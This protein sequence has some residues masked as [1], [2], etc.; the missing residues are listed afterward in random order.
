MA[1]TDK[2]TL[3]IRSL[4]RGPAPRYITDADGAIF[5]VEPGETLEI[6]VT[7]ALAQELKDW[8]DAKR[9]DIEVVSGGSVSQQAIDEQNEQAS[10]AVKK[11][12]APPST[13]EIEEL[14]KRA[15]PA[16]HLMRQPAPLATPHVDE[17]LQKP[18]KPTARRVPKRGPKHQ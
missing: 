16:H 12:L 6:K 14:K 8:T 2:V 9:G 1:K 13:E 15:T 4:S 7:P 18:V 10:E 3:T 17:A 5:K 11:A